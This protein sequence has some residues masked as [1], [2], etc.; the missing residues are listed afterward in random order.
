MKQESNYFDPNILAHINGLLLRARLVV[1]GLLLGIHKSRAKGLSTDF[2]EYREYSPGDDVRHLDW[3][4]YAKFDRYFIKEYRRTTNL[5]TQILLDVSGSMDYS[6]AK[7]SKF[8]YGCLLAACLSHLMLRQQDAVGLVTFSEKVVNVVPARA[9]QG[10][11]M[12]ILEALEGSRPQGKSAAGPVLQQL[13]AG[14]AGRG[15]VVLISDLLDESEEVLKGIKHLRYRGNDVIVFHLLDRDEL[16][17]PFSE[18]TRFEDLEED[19]KLLTD[20]REIRK[21]YLQAITSLI[22]T[23][24]GGC[25]ANSVDYVLLN[26]STPLDRGLVS[27]LSWRDKGIFNP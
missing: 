19:L 24:R 27:Y 26:T 17:F 13:A 11:L 5:K 23:Y 6:S 3:K 25:G 20:P 2:E 15:L 4:S 9:R 21:T 8:D 7:L 22:D 10:H 16:D 12:A 1:D 18:V 14:L